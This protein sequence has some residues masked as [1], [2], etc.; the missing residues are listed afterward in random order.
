[1]RHMPLDVI[2]AILALIALPIYLRARSR[3]HEH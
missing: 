1:V 2:F 3:R